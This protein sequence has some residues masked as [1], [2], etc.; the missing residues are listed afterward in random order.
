[1]TGKLSGKVGVITGASAGL[2]LAVAADFVNEG[3]QVVIMG[4]REPALKDAAAVLGAAASYV[5]GDVTRLAD[6]DRLFAAVK[7]RHGQVDILVAN[8]GGVGGG[9]VAT[10][11]EQDFDALVTLNVKSVFFTVQKALPLLRSP[12]AIV[13]M[14]STSAEIALPGGSLYAASKSALRSFVRSWAA[15]LAP[16]GARVNLVGPGPTDTPLVE[17][18]DARGGGPSLDRLISTRGAIHRRGHAD[19]IAAAVRFLS[20]EESGWTTGAALYVDGGIAYL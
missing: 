14:G 1:M 2:G 20:S 8:A 19:E 3:A 15:E 7:D 18:I 9:P 13:V 10:C 11:S 6:L 5:C 16:L 12:S 17:S 4:R